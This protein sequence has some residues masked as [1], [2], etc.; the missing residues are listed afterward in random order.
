MNKSEEILKRIIAVEEAKK[1][2]PAFGKAEGFSFAV[3]VDSLDSNEFLTQSFGRGLSDRK[4]ISEFINTAKKHYIGAKGKPTMS[5]V[6]AWVKDNGK[7]IQF[8][9]KWKSDSQ[10]N[11]ADVVEIYV[12]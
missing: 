11:K 12:K 9:A 1:R 3:N 6:K 7:D 5:A 8:F 10:F 2:K 4:K